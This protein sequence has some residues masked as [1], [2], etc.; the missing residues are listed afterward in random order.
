MVQQH[1][2]KVSF[3]SSN[4]T[5]GSI[6]LRMKMGNNDQFQKKSG[7][8]GWKGKEEMKS[9]HETRNAMKRDGLREVKETEQLH[10]DD[11]L[12]DDSYP[13]EQ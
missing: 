12:Q 1:S 8:A 5:R 2:C 7:R 3:V 13:E 9:S 4:P 11:L 6:F 10:E